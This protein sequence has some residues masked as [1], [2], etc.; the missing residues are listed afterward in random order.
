MEVRISVDANQL[1][2]DI[3]TMVERKVG[4]V[5]SSSMVREQLMLK[6]AKEMQTYSLFPE[7]SGAMKSGEGPR[8]SQN[9]T[10]VDKNR[11]VHNRTLY[12]RY[13]RYDVASHA[14]NTELIIDPI[15]ERPSRDVHYGSHHAETLHEIAQAAAQDYAF[16]DYAA[17]I[18]GDKMRKS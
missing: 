5:T 15:E 13:G 11:A 10:W 12:P 18:I 4:A 1:K 3:S 7:D 17:E 9:R 6:L 2:R 16:L 8:F 14:R